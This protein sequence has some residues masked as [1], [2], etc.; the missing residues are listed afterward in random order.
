M[1]LK[2][3]TFHSVSKFVQLAVANDNY[4]CLRWVFPL[5]KQEILVFIKKSRC[6]FWDCDSGITLLTVGIM[7]VR[8][9]NYRSL[10][11]VNMHK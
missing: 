10:R 2:H 9:F 3:Q 7:T 11:S 1:N 8:M 4:A 6:L 5:A